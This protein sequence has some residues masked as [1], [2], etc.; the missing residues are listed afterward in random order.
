M[1]ARGGSDM[2]STS[3]QS[4]GSE[5]DDSEETSQSTLSNNDSNSL[6]A[7]EDDT[8]AAA[9]LVSVKKENSDSSSNDALQFKEPLP[10]APKFKVPTSTVKQETAVSS[11]SSS[12]LQNVFKVPSSDTSS[13]PPEKRKLSAL[14][15]IMEVCDK[16]LFKHTSSINTLLLFHMTDKTKNHHDRHFYQAITLSTISSKIVKKL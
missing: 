13:R 14:D 8:E 12:K 9:Q 4:G 1:M 10:V 15:E 6:S 7:F 5:F 16:L 11:A 2:P 3:K